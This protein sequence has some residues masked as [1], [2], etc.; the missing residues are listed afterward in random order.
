MIKYD[1]TGHRFGRLTVLSFFET[2]KHYRKMWLCRCDCGTEKAVCGKSMRDGAIVSCGCYKAEKAKQVH[3]THG[4]TGSKAYHS[5]SGMISRCHNSKNPKFY[6]YGEKG[7]VVC[8]RWK[9]SFSDFISDM[10]DPPSKYHS[11]DRID[12]DGNYCPEN[13]RWASPKEQSAHIRTNHLVTFKDETKH[14]SEWA[15]H[16]GCSKETLFGRIRL[17]W[18]DER[19]IGEPI[20]H[21][22]KA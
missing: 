5:W 2:R 4:K 13:C 17:G 10:G 21:R 6:M 14:V 15:R 12:G 16:L 8:E 3:T 11:I 22:R 7:I 1:M 18:N 20:K 19:V 9:N